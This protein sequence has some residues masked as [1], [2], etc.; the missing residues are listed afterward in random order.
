M[1]GRK[2]KC[3]KDWVVE[4]PDDLQ[5]LQKMPTIQG[6]NNREVPILFDRA[7]NRSKKEAMGL[8]KGA[9]FFC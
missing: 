2:R 4:Y 3:A 8:Y 7:D 1:A 6:E 9:P 5:T